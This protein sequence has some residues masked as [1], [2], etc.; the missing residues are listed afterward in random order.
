M[1]S[2]ISRFSKL[3]TIIDMT[4]SCRFSGCLADGRYQELDVAVLEAGEGVAEVNGNAVGDACRDLQHPPL[5]SG[6]GKA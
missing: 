6:A 1:R 2:A 4:Y 3:K 5:A